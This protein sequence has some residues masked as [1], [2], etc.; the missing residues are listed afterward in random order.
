MGAPDQEPAPAAKCQ[1]AVVVAADDAENPD[2]L[3]VYGSLAPGQ[4]NSHQLDGLQ[5]RWL[6]GGVRGSLFH[7]GWGATMGYPAIVLDPA[8]PE[9]E[10]QIFESTDLPGHWPRLDDFE[11]PRYQRVL[12]PVETADGS[13]EASIYVFKPDSAPAAAPSSP[14][15]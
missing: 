8:G 2:R 3:A 11:G 13:L 10:V 15:P 14:I 1:T 5:G 7:A 12:V 9:V 6:K 4:S